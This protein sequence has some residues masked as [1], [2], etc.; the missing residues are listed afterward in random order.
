MGD[1]RK[2][3]QMHP[4]DLRP[5]SKTRATLLLYQLCPVRSSQAGKQFA[6]NKKGQIFFQGAW[7]SVGSVIKR[8]CAARSKYAAIKEDLEFREKQR[9]TQRR[10]YRNNSGKKAAHKRE[11]Y[12]ARTSY[13]RK[14]LHR[15]RTENERRAKPN[16]AIAFAIGEFECG[17]IS[18]DEFDRRISEALTRVD[19]ISS[20][21]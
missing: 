12:N 3:N 21:G 2:G 18:F 6:I 13:E 9:E 17:K 19:E 11:V 4:R 8:R 16:R 7:R 10:T 5:N 14:V 1:S 15:R 20:E